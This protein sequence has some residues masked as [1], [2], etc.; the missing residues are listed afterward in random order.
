MRIHDL[1]HA[2]ASIA[3]NEGVSLPVIGLVLGHSQSRTTERYAHVRS[4]P[5]T[6]AVNKV[7][8]SIARAIRS[9][10]D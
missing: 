4:E 5:A 2:A 9:K 7:G 10:N 8:D 6:N 1:R 3:V